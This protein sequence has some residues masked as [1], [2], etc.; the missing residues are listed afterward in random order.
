MELIYLSP[1]EVLPACLATMFNHKHI[2][3]AALAAGFMHYM[4]K[5]Y[6]WKSLIN[7]KNTEIQLINILLSR[8]N[9]RNK[10]KIITNPINEETNLSIF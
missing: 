5:W 8:S 9:L 3:N 6:V 10:I 4:P 1:P 7:C 2:S